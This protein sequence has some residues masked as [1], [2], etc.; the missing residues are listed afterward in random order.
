MSAFQAKSDYGI[1][2]F[3][4]TLAQQ[5]IGR[6]AFEVDTEIVELLKKGAGDALAS[7]TFSMTQP[8][9][10]SLQEHFASFAKIVEIAN[11]TLYRRTQRYRA[12]YMLIAPE[13]LQVLAFVPTW[14]PVEVSTAN[15]PYMAGTLGNLKVYVTPSFANGEFVLGVN[16]NAMETSA[17][18]YAPYMPII[19]TQML[20][21]AD[22]SMSQGLTNATMK[23]AC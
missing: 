13:I 22:G 21:Y 11:A 6:L 8:V 2:D 1:N 18:I 3:A 23:I 17:A 20:G 12:T 4:N 10:V 14:K 16:G 15:G 19:P 7:L 9:G 5:A